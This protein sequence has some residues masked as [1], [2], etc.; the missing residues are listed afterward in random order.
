MQRQGLVGIAFHNA[1][2]A[3]NINIHIHRLAHNRLPLLPYPDGALSGGRFQAAFADPLPCCVIGNGRQRAG[4]IGY[5]E[6]GAEII[7]DLG[8][9]LGNAVQQQLNFSS[10]GIDLHIGGFPLAAAPG[11]AG[12]RIGTAPDGHEQLLPVP[13]YRAGAD[14]GRFSGTPDHRSHT[15][16]SGVAAQ[17]VKGTGI[18]QEPGTGLAKA[19][20][21]LAIVPGADAHLPQVV[22]G[23]PHKVAV[24]IGQLLN[25]SPVDG[26][27]LGEGLAA[28]HQSAG[29]A[30]RIH[31]IAGGGVVVARNV[32]LIQAG[33]GGL[34]H[35]RAGSTLRHAP[36]HF[37]NHFVELCGANLG[38]LFFLLFLLRLHLAVHP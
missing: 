17:N 4:D 20:V 16:L 22:P 15:G 31:L 7:C 37:G 9:A 27:I 38:F 36:A 2:F 21:I 13:V 10:I 1:V 3:H 34:V 23:C 32:Q 12:Q 33:G 18:R 8:S 19:P 5:R 6:P 35:L 11:P 25:Q 14:I 26:Q 30:N 24:Q 29:M 28:H